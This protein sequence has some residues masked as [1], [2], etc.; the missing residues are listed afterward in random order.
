VAVYHLLLAGIAL[1]GWVALALLAFFR[2]LPQEWPDRQAPIT[3]L[4]LAVVLLCGP[5][6]LAAGIGLR[7]RRRWGRLLTLG[8]GGLAALLAVVGIALVCVGT[9]RIGSAQDLTFLALLPAYSIAV[10]VDLWKESPGAK[11][12]TEANAAANRDGRN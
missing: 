4:F 10:F 3:D 2:Q 12:E 1:L 6:F 9:L 5:A 11:Q 7:C 8:L